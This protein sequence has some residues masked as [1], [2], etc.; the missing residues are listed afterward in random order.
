MSERVEKELNS[1]SD[2]EDKKDLIVKVRGGISPERI[3]NLDKLSV[4]DDL[5]KCP[6]CFNYLNNPYECELCGGLFCE[7]CIQDWLKNKEKCPMRCPELKIKRADINSRKLLN[8]I[9][10][11]CQNYPDCNF[12]A[13]YWD[14]LSHQEKCNFHKV[15]CP[16][17]ICKFKGKFS[18]LQSHLISCPYGNVQCGFCN[19]LI[20]RKDMNEH[21]DNHKKN[22]TFIKTKLST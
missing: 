5:I 11:H 20:P 16:N 22:K 13:K 21:L 7:D 4:I 19:A 9:E 3:I 10:L 17:Q 18:D 1:L 14:L 2:S 6:I 8:V 15:K 12:T